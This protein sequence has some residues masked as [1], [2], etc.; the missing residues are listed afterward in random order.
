MLHNKY[1]SRRNIKQDLN[2]NYERFVFL[3]T[4]NLI[5]T[6][7]ITFFVSLY[8]KM[9]SNSIYIIHLKIEPKTNFVS[10]IYCDPNSKVENNYLFGF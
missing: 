4:F 3:H 10:I 9:K 8:Q 1:M 2:T 5:V 7:I 6:H